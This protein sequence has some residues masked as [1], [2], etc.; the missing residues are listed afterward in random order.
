MIV[1]DILLAI[2]AKHIMAERMVIEI[3]NG[4]KAWNIFHG[5]SQSAGWQHY[6][7][8]WDKVKMKL[9]VDGEEKEKADLRD[10][11]NGLIGSAGATFPTR[12]ALGRASTDETVTKLAQV[13]YDDF[14]IWERPFNGTEVLEIYNT[15]KIYIP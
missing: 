13:Y 9:F 1:S 10:F 11:R 7:I 5:C 3:W 2:S 14:K 15:G 4:S 6:M 12:L 8:T